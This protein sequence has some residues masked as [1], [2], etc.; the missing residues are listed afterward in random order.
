MIRE[1]RRLRVLFLPAWYPEADNPIRGVFVREHAR[2][3]QLY[4]DVV[5]MYP[6][7]V[8][9]R[10]RGFYDIRDDIE[11]GIRTVRVRYWRPRSPVVAAL[12]SMYAQWSAMNRL[13]RQGF[14]PDVIHAHVYYAGTRAALLGRLYKIPVVLSE[15]STAFPRRTLT[16]WQRL[17]ARFAMRA[18][19]RVLPVSESLRAAI[20]AYGISAR[21]EVIPN[22]VST[23]L[24][25]PEPS[26][27]LT[28]G[29]R[30]PKRLLTVSLL[31]PQKGVPYLLEALYELRQRRTDVVLD[32]VGDGESRQEY[33]ELVTRLG[34]GDVVRFHGMKPRA[35]TAEF[36]RRCDIFVLPSLF[37]TFGVVLIEALASGKPV[38]A[39]DSGGPGE[40]INDAVGRLV[41]PG[42]AAALAAALDEMLDAYGEFDAERLAAYARDRYS[43]E[44]VGRRL[45]EVY[46]A[47]SKGNFV[48][49]GHGCY[50]GILP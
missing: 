35:E 36:M 40:I 45:H 20:Q 19:Q 30:G 15:H 18:V 7:P 27:V 32:I 25:T 39:T 17:H 3:A 50:T 9:G 16:W 46:G 6:E 10:L 5:V 13:M 38:V 11:D 48:F 34:L 26:S 8:A 1:R 28:Q 42:D 37:E 31:R 22:V 33:E 4:D 29:S 23:E 44:S 2:A 43:P 41:A 12:V 47:V 24:F 14:R 21:F 49:S